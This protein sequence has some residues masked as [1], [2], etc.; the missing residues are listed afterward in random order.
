MRTPYLLALLIVAMLAASTAAANPESSYSER[1]TFR[2]EVE[3]TGAFSLVCDVEIAFTYGSERSTRERL[4]FVPEPFYAEVTKLKGDLSGQRLGRD[5]IGVEV[6]EYQDV[7]MTGGRVHYLEFPADIE[8]G[9]VARYSYREVYRDA[10]YLPILYVPNPEHVREYEVVIEHP[11]G[12]EAEFSFFYPRTPLAPRV[13]RSDRKR[14][15]LTF[16]DLGQETALAFSPFNGF[17]AALLIHLSQNGEAVNPATEQQFAA[18]YRGRIGALDGAGIADLA[19]SLEREAP[20]ETVAAI[21]DHVRSSIRYVADERGENAIVPRAPGT[22]LANGYGDCKDRAF[23]VAALAEAVGIKV[24][25]VLLSTE[26]VPAFDHAHVGLYNHVIAAYHD[27]EETVF[28]DPTHRYVPFGD[29]P[30]SDAWASA[31]I[32]GDEPVRLQIPP[33]DRL[34]LVDIEI[35]GGLAELGRA[36]ARVTVRG[37]YLAEFARLRAEGS[38]LDI[39][40]FL[41][42]V[43]TE[44][45]HKI[46]LD[47]FSLSDESSREATFTAVA[48]LADFVVSSPTRRY[49]PKT[50]FRTVDA[51]VMERA[52]DAYALYFGDRPHFRLALELGTDGF[53]A[54][55]DSLRIGEAP[56][57]RA[58]LAY[59]A[60]L[61]G[62]TE[63][64]V[65]IEYVFRQ[66]TKHAEGEVKRRYLDAAREYLQART[67]MFIFRQAAVVSEDESSG[68]LP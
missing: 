50:P 32:L 19:G 47:G 22:V 12:V 31:L 57:N 61:R 7:F 30:E 39:E 65:R 17:Q 29:L 43:T 67:D 35:K 42:I 52:D 49:V 1:R 36:Q 63:G 4:F 14:T 48:D 9:D 26:P 54:V 6:P 18:W 55:D 46:A 23:L 33:A 11:D 16:E 38:P 25:V 60:R 13:D 40:N 41:S 66:G 64:P 27:G 20:R 37:D 2:L 59:D 58:A 3:S 8:V 10:A 24:D 21:H 5:Q 34:P 28:F 62:S 56:G 68:E 53:T 44:R 51:E 45:L 15:V